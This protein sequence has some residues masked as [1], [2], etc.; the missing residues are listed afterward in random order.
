MASVSSSLVRDFASDK[1]QHLFRQHR[2]LLLLLLV[3]FFAAVQIIGIL[4]VA[5]STEAREMHVAKLMSDGESLILPLR[6][7]IVPS[8]PP[9]YHWISSTMIVV[10]DFSIAFATRLV[11]VCSGL[12]ILCLVYWQQYRK[13]DSRSLVGAFVAIVVLVSF[14]MFSRLV[15]D[16]RVD[17]LFAAL[18]YAAYVSSH[19][20]SPLRVN[21]FWL[22]VSLAILTKGPLGLLLPLL[23]SGVRS[24]WLGQWSSFRRFFMPFP[25]AILF[26]LLPLLWYFSAF[27]IGGNEFAWRVGFEN[28][29]RFAVGDPG[30]DSSVLVY[31]K[32]FFVKL[33]PWS[34]L[35]AIFIVRDVFYYVKTR[36]QLVRYASL[37][38]FIAGFGFFCLSSGKRASYLLPLLPMLAIYIAESLVTS[39][40]ISRV[41]CK[42]WFSLVA[43]ACSS[44]LLAFWLSAPLIKTISV[45]AE[46][47]ISYLLRNQ[48]TVGTLVLLC[49]LLSLFS[50][51]KGSF[52]LSAVAYCCIVLTFYGLGLGMKG[53]LKDFESM[54][55]KI[56][57]LVPEDVELVLLKQRY[58]EYF[59]PL[60]LLLDRKVRILEPDA[61]LSGNKWYMTRLNY[62]EEIQGCE[63]LQQGRFATISDSLRGR[64][65]RDVVVFTCLE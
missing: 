57:L 60:Q 61:T 56:N 5:S 27:A 53:Q 14:P 16:A 8:K 7:G 49:F 29:Q 10:F 34:W 39:R 3:V 37:L 52:R 19:T 45:E 64:N 17:M 33:A 4:H 28:V 11:S 63:V 42:R 62:Y 21:C 24:I 23:L 38:C 50:W 30:R 1:P 43:L 12:A 54:A 13:S 31:I 26:L 47:P 2:W 59:D 35:A 51:V 36:E 9:L 58:E 32:A 25:G 46:L 6:N 55:E 48:R 20:Y 40:S 44:L 15:I 65:L 18:F 41:F 22:F